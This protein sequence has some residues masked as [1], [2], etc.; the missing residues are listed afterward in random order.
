MPG[1]LFRDHA[2]ELNPTPHQSGCDNQEAPQTVTAPST[3]DGNLST[4]ATG[5]AT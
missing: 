1:Q 3:P 5:A 4:L 2:E